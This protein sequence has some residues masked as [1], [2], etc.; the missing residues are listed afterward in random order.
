MLET[1]ESRMIS[2]EHVCVPARDPP[3]GR[4]GE[5]EFVLF[6]SASTDGCT[7]HNHSS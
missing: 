3:M 6:A 1:E 7:E 2:F 4:F 5:T